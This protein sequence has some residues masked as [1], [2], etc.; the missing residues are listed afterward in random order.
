[1]S[2]ATHHMSSMDPY[3]TDTDDFQQSLSI[4]SIEETRTCLKFAMCFLLW[5]GPV[6]GW[7]GHVACQGLKKGLN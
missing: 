3:K 2:P 1:M 4:G 7:C 6:S 5:A